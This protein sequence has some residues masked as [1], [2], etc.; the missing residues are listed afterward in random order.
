MNYSSSPSTHSTAVI[1]STLL[2]NRRR[3][4]KETNL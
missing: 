1:T 3:I 4:K 2:D